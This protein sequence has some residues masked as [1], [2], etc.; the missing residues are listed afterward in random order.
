LKTLGNRRQQRPEGVRPS[1]VPKG[2]TKRA[3]V[4]L[5]IRSADF[6][7]FNFKAPTRCTIV[8]TASAVVT[9]GSND[10]NPSNNQALV[11]L[12]VTDRHDPEQTAT[13]ET[14]I[15]SVA[16]TTISIADTATNAI[17]KLMAVVG[18][19]DY[20][21][22]AETLGDAITLH[23]STSCTGLT[24]ST[25]VCDI[26]TNSDTV[27]VKGG[28]IKIC[29]LT[30]TADPAQINTPS[31]MS[32]QRCTVSLT[33]VGPTSP[34]TSPLDPSNNTTEVTIDVT[35]RNDF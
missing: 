33:A 6:T 20:R 35:D 16:P 13:H 18:N 22:K 30:A 27:T 17:K 21:P 3:K 10:P 12:N 4:P 9:G 29:K 28:M 15:K 5:T 8:L 2:M 23:A 24:L 7:S 25:P 32:P 31:R 34:E 11:E 14:T 26:T 1:L 19:A